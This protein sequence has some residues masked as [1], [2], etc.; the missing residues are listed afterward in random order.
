MC[1]KQDT[2]VIPEVTKIPRGTSSET[3]TFV[4]ICTL[5]LGDRFDHGL[6]TMASLHSFAGL[7]YTR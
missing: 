3:Q 2:V 1:L 7:Q 5:L 4:I 6:Y